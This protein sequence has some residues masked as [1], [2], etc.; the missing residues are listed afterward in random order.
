[1]ATAVLSNH[2]KHELAAGNIDFDGDTF[3]IML[4]NTS[5]TFDKDAHAVK[6]DVVASELA[7]GNGYTSG[8]ETLANVALT[9]DD[10]N[11]RAQVAWDDPQWDASGGSIGPTGSA[12]IYD[13][14]H[15]S[16]CI[17]GVIDYGVDYTIQDGSSFQ[18]KD[19]LARLT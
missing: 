9:E 18:I 16:D 5:F 14:S 2:F 3:K 12:I 10:T 13:D 6:A 17:V 15:P 11:D 7:A 19:I 8:G 4:M 1:M